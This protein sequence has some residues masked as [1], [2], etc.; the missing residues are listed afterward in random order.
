MTVDTEEFFDTQRE[1]SH[2][3]P[4]I[5]SGY[6]SAWA[7]VMVKKARQPVI[8]YLD[9]FAGKGR[10]DDGSDSTPILLCAPE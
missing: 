9:L 8:G 4:A 1:P 2:I 10:F 5:V 7:N 3:K 6:F